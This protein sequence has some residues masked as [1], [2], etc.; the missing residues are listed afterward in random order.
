MSSPRWEYVR[1]YDVEDALARDAWAVAGPSMSDSL[2][3]G[4]YVI[5]LPTG[6][7]HGS[8]KKYVKIDPQPNNAGDVVYYKHCK[9]TDDIL[10]CRKILPMLFNVKFSVPLAGRAI[11]AAEVTAAL[12]G[13][14]VLS[15]TFNSTDTIDDVRMKTFQDA[16]VL[17]PSLISCNTPLKFIYDDKVLHCRKQLCNVSNDIKKQLAPV[18]ATLKK[19]IVKTSLKK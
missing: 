2:E 11:V 10:A 18:A 13:L 5:W 15:A 14:H 4:C 3:Q 1:I 6:P 19:K 17:W 8:S 16:S 12:S 9:N 7:Y